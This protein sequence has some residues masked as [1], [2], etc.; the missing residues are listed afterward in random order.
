MSERAERGGRAE[1]SSSA[2]FFCIAVLRLAIEPFGKL[3]FG[4]SVLP[5]V[6]RISGER[7]AR[8]GGAAG[9][10]QMEDVG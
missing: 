5:D 4:I 6:R 1:H 9:Q 10:G 2:R 8:P 3:A 7:Q